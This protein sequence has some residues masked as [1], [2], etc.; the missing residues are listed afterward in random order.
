MQKVIV[1][2]RMITE[3][4]KSPP[5]IYLQYLHQQLL[6][7]QHYHTYS[8]DNIIQMPCPGKRLQSTPLTTDCKAT[9][10][11]TAKYLSSS[12]NLANFISFKTVLYNYLSFFYSVLV[13]CGGR[14]VVCGDGGHLLLWQTCSS[15]LSD[16]TKR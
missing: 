8:I 5:H 1:M 13:L 2:M 10:S 15:P 11:K 16:E 7:N 14:H 3:D 9:K 12:I 6:N 4:R